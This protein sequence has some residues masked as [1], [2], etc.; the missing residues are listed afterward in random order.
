MSKATGTNDTYDEEIVSIFFECLK[1]AGYESRYQQENSIEAVFEKTI[2][3]A[4]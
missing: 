2:S 1:Q 4:A 3:I